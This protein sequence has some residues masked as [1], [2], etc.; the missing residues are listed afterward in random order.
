MANPFSPA[1]EQGLFAR[2]SAPAFQSLTLNVPKDRFGAVAS[3]FS[4]SG[5][6]VAAPSGKVYGN[7]HTRLPVESV[8]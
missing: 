1:A 3:Y 4:N 6:A 7:R 2:P 5:S 8:K